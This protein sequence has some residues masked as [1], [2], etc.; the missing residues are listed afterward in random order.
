MGRPHTMEAVCRASVPPTLSK[1]AT[2]TAIMLPQNILMLLGGV[3]SPVTSLNCFIDMADMDMV[4]DS[5]NVTK[6][7][8]TT[9]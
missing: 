3:A 2:V 9:G 8:T 6:D 4:I 1:T 5:A 7:N